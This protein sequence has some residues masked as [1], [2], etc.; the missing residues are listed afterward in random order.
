MP[1]WIYLR[2]DPDAVMSNDAADAVLKRIEEAGDGDRFITVAG[3]QYGHDDEP[4]SGYIRASAI[5]AVLP[6]H[7]RQFEAE[8]DDPPDWYTQYGP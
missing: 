5:A 4:R 7:P 8:L 2:G 6:M 1:C 3:V